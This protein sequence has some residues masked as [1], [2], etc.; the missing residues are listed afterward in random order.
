[1]HSRH[2]ALAAIR[3]PSP[4]CTGLRPRPSSLPDVL[5]TW[6]DTTNY[7]MSAR[8][9]RQ[10]KDLQYNGTP[11]DNLLASPGYDHDRWYTVRPQIAFQ[12][13]EIGSDSFTQAKGQESSKPAAALLSAS[14]SLEGLGILGQVD[15]TL[16]DTP[17][18]V[19]ALVEPLFYELS[20]PDGAP[21][22]RPH[23][24]ASAN[25]LSAVALCSRPRASPCVSPR[26]LVPCP[27]T[28]A[29]PAPGLRSPTAVTH[30]NVRS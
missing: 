27:P 4:R 9:M 12:A 15:K 11:I 7:I 3:S 22:A 26:A 6:Y 17:A 16:M 1:M 14:P 5:H 23:N 30:L 28:L 10:L 29:R 8:K 18:V 13:L 21:L 20:D 24:D 25:L 2:H 19:Y